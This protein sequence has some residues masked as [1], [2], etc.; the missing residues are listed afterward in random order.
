MC[1]VEI[2][3]LFII[4]SQEEGNKNYTFV[5][6]PFFEKKIFILF[7]TKWLLLLFTN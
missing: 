3:K 1:K 6:K 2:N 4:M 5:Q 7:V